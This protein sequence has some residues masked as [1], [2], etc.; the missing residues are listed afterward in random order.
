[1]A[2]AAQASTYELFEIEKNG[3]AIDISGADPFGAKTTSL[4]YYESLLSP[5]STAV[6]SLIDTGGSFPTKYDRQKRS[7]TLDSALPLTGDVSIRF[8]IVNSATGKVLDFTRKPFL[9]D[10]KL[11]PSDE[12]NR[13]SMILGLVSSTANKNKIQVY[14]KY[15][16]NISDSIEKLIR[17]YYGPDQKINRSTTKNSWSFTG[18]DRTVAK[19]AI[20]AARQSIPEKGNPGYFFYETQF[21]MNFRSI[22]EL[23]RQEPKATYFRTDVLQSGVDDDRNNFKILLKSTIKSEDISTASLSGAYQSRN[24]FVDLYSYEVFHTVDKLSDIK[25]ETSLGKDVEVPSVETLPT[26]FH[27]LDV[28]S[29]ESNISTKINN[30]PRQWQAK[31][32]MRYNSLFSQIIQIQVPCNLSL[33]AGDTI[34]CNFEMVTQDNKAQGSLDPSTS[35]KY[36]ILNLCHHFDSL[37]SYTSMTLVR[38]SYGLHTNKNK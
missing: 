37:R 9:F 8:K 23:I 17:D 13:Q 6:I 30:D 22:D 2:N 31:S 4:D 32:K 12:S 35:G 19:L 5:N 24:V 1:M 36:L 25:L 28:G 27:L 29:L 38:D 3:V 16:G 15:S 18:T 11:S 14:K 26:H 34:S 7:G 20:E 21:G 10:K 33:M